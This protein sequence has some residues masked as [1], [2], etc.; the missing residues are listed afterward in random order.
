MVLKA[1]PVVISVSILNCGLTECSRDTKDSQD[2]SQSWWLCRSV[3]TV[4]FWA[5]IHS[6]LKQTRCEGERP[7]MKYFAARLEA[8]SDVGNLFSIFWIVWI[9]RIKKH[10]TEGVARIS[11]SA[12]C[13]C[14]IRAIT[15]VSQTEAQTEPVVIYWFNPNATMDRWPIEIWSQI[16][17]LACTDNGFTGRS[18]SLV[19]RYIYESSKPTKLQS[20]SVSTPQQIQSL[21]LLIRKT[22]PEYRRVRNLFIY[23]HPGPNKGD[24]QHRT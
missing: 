13:N 12:V 4:Q 15:R 9:F 7:W 6:F 24:P 19:S 18:L 14:S 22:S 23:I 17:A 2:Y 8:R 5:S 16:F 3:D 21:A 10:K 20:L 1:F 11:E